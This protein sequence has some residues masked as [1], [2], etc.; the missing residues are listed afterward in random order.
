MQR[1]SPRL[2]A[3]VAA[4]VLL[5][6][7]IVLFRTSDEAVN[8]REAEAR[9]SAAGQAG[10]VP[11]ELPTVVVDA[12]TVTRDP[13]R[14]IVD[15][16]GVI[17]AA[18]DVVIG[19][20]VSGRVMSVEAPEHTHVAEGDLLVRLD[21]AL[22]RAAVERARAAL[23]RAQAS[24]RLADAEMTRQRE[25]STRGVSSTA[26][27]DR[28][29][30]ADTSSS[31]EVAEARAAL[32]DAETRLAKTEIRAPF[33]GVVSGL[34]LEP[35]AYLNP[36]EPVAELADLS[37]VEIEVGLSDR[38]ILAVRH[39]DPVRVS[40]EAMAGQ[41]FDGHVFNPGRTADAATRKFP[42]AVR[43]SN[44][45]DRLLPGMLGTVRFEIGDSRETV[46]VPRR[47]VFSEFDLDYVYILEPSDTS[48][49]AIAHRRRVTAR[50]VPFRPES[51][52]IRA[53]LEAGERIASS[54]IRNLRDGQLVGTREGLA[55]E[56][57]ATAA[58]EEPR[59]RDSAPVSPAPAPQDAP[60]TEDPAS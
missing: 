43:V 6:I 37:E 22:P 3:F 19:A 7:A 4:A 12:M 2:L 9:R 60:D 1:F 58:A 5:L 32:L 55:T 20:E 57:T 50:P 26:E 10:A 28:A 30:S 54:G 52:E 33:A 17:R 51:L 47:S 21:P 36:G 49:N 15:I 34:D 29:V 38:Q 18:R 48:D 56:T 23:L 25:L 42:V 31:A 27:L 40:V 8:A 41:W 16:A 44:P 11:T 59:P 45:D 46:R 24:E 13:A 35:G 39:G 14:T 53:G